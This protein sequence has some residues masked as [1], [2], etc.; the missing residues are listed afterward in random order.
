VSAEC[1]FDTPRCIPGT[2]DDAGVYHEAGTSQDAAT[3]GFCWRACFSSGLCLE[4]FD[5]CPGFAC[6][7]AKCKKIG[8]GD[9]GQGDSSTGD[10]SDAPMD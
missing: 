7:G 2:L 1:C 6:E 9:A 10:A 5:C 8:P 4:P 3:A